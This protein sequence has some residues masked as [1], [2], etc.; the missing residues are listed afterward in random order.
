MKVGWV[1]PPVSR[2]MN[3]LVENREISQID[4]SIGGRPSIKYTK[5]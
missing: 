1:A 2:Y 3:Y 4:Y 5:H